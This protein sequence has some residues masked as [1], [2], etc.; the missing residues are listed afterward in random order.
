M[1]ALERPPSLPP[2][3]SAAAYAD[4]VRE[5]LRREDSRKESLEKRGLAVVTTSGAIVALLFALAGFSLRSTTYVLPHSARIAILVAAAVFVIAAC[6]AVATNH[7]F[8]T[9]A[10]KPSSL[11]TAVRENWETTELSLLKQEVLTDINI[12]EST[13]STNNLRA[14]LL[15]WATIA[16]GLA[17]MIVGVAIGLALFI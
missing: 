16:E 6:L 17:T 14:N 8:E 10:V 2:A 3:P 7:P 11:R 1:A 12:W 5:Q 4:Y 9:Q 15:F 13:R